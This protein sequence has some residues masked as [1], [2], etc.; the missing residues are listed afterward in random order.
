MSRSYLVDSHTFSFIYQ[1]CSL[2]LKL[3]VGEESCRL[4][5]HLP[6][7]FK[8]VIVFII[9]VFLLPSHLLLYPILL[10]F[11]IMIRVHGFPKQGLENSLFQD[12]AEHFVALKNV[13]RA[14]R[15]PLGWPSP[16]RVCTVSLWETTTQ[17]F[18]GHSRGKSPGMGGRL[19]CPT[20]SKA[21]IVSELFLG[22]LPHCSRL[23]YGP[24]RRWPWPIP[25]ISWYPIAPGILVLSGPASG[26][27]KQCK[28]SSF[29]GLHI[30]GKTKTRS[31]KFQG[32]LLSFVWTG[33]ALSC[34][35]HMVG[36]YILP[37]TVEAWRL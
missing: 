3:K 33:A 34:S 6:T 2:V 12:I 27:P 36:V 26:W 22:P 19:R 28:W 30:N 23:Q 17:K 31:G 5:E 20:A 9:F 16:G 13:L 21:F 10:P 24:R 29:C 37:Y 1:H 25:H 7:L 14:N 11:P 18:C 32:R 4:S 15:R 35:V 8:I